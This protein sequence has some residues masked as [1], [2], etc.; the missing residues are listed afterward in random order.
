MLDGWE[1]AG[2]Q[3][4]TTQI[5]YFEVKLGIERT[6]TR[7]RRDQYRRTLSRI[8]QSVPVVPF[9]RAASEV[10]V[11]RQL[12][13]FESGRPAA[14]IVLFVA[15]IAASRR[16]EAIVT[17]DVDDFERMGLTSVQSY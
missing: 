17:R 3:L 1:L 2:T 16:C 6:V 13:L 14:S 9:D 4:I 15:A 10:A 7:D 11:K 8:L 5:N 12:E